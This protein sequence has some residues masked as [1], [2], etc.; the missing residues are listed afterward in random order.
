MNVDPETPQGQLIGSIAAVLSRADEAL[1]TQSNATSIFRSSGQQIDGLA[2]ILSVRRNDAQRS[3]VTVTLSGVPGTLISMG[4]RASTTNNDLFR[5]TA[6]AQLAGNGQVSA[7]MESVETG[8]IT[9]AAGTLINIVDVVSGWEG[10]TNPSAASLGRP[11]EQD[12]LYRRRYFQDLSRNALTPIAAVESAVVEVTGVRGARAF[13]NDTPNP[14]TQQN[15]TIPANSIWTAV[16]G[17]A[18]LDIAQAIRRSKPAGI[19]TNG[20]TTVNAPHPSGFDT[21]IQFTRVELVEI[22][23][24]LNITT[25]PNFPG[26]GIALIENRILEYVNG[27]FAI[28]QEGFF[29]TDGLMIAEDLNRF[30]IV[31]TD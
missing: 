9:A 20:T 31:Y 8:P 18:D 4:T 17:G 7:T 30:Q 16:E 22:E 14:V 25:G 21:P 11:Q 5:L 10:V 13:E 27:T 26:N 24:A 3:T 29:E 28:D 6:D 23:V 12:T 1:V 15:V 19:P 2:S